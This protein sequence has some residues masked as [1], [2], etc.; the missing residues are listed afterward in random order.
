MTLGKFLPTDLS[1]LFK[2]QQWLCLKKLGAN[3]VKSLD[4]IMYFCKSFDGKGTRRG[5]AP[6]VHIGAY[7]CSAK[8]KKK[9]PLFDHACKTYW[10]LFQPFLVYVGNLAQNST[11][12]SLSNEPLLLI[13]SCDYNM[14]SFLLL[15]RANNV[16]SI[17]VKHEAIT[18]RILG[19]VSPFFQNYAWS[20]IRIFG[21]SKFSTKTEIMLMFVQNKWV[22]EIQVNP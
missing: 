3:M 19:Y 13:R 21:N 2:T 6:P 12:L 20:Y 9:L 14:P 5:I 18:L 4:T 7:S 22:L 11:T 15:F 8:K 17:I 16:L 1:S 10:F